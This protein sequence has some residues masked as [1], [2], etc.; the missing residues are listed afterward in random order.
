MYL[1]VDLSS[2]IPAVGLA[3]PG[4]F[5]AF[6]VV[7]TG[8]PGQCGRLACALAAI[9]RVDPE[10]RYAYLDTGAVKRLAGAD[11]GAQWSADFDHMVEYAR[12]RGWVDA[13]DQI[14]AH[15]EWRGARRAA[16]R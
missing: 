16:R 3:D 15:V 2:A 11:A 6:S 4:S 7:V 10:A 14:R 12:S 5:G 1:T 13:T 9:G 8:P